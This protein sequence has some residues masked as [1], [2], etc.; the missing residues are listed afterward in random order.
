MIDEPDE[1]EDLDDDSVCLAEASRISGLP[2]EVLVDLID[3]G[4]IE[5]SSGVRFW[6]INPD[7]LPDPLPPATHHR[8]I[9][10]QNS[11]DGWLE[12]SV[13]PGDRAPRRERPP[14]E[15][16]PEAPWRIVRPADA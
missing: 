4:Q 12:N 1:L 16:P 2:R 10:L 5:A 13:D 14:E 6:R 7:S 9:V 15:P 8:P 3:Q 11:R